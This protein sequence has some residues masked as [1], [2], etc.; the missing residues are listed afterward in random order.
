MK[1]VSVI[2]ILAVLVLSINLISAIDMDIKSSFY[3]GETMQVEIPDVFIEGLRLENIG[4]YQGD[5]VHITPAGSGLIKSGYSYFYYAVLPVSDGPYSLKIENIKYWESSSQSTEPIVRNFSIIN[6]TSSYLSFNPGYLSV[7]KDF[8]ITVLAYGKRQDVTATFAPTNFQKTLNINLGPDSY[9]TFYIP[10]TGITNV[11]KSEVKINSYTIPVI[12]TPGQAIKDPFNLSG[13]DQLKIINSLEDVMDFY[14]E[15]IV[16]TLLPGDDYLYEIEL[17]NEINASIENL[18]ISS[19]DKEIKVSPQNI[20]ELKKH[21][22]IKINVTL[23]FK[24]ENDGWINVTYQNYSIIIPVLIKIAEIQSDVQ[25]NI[26]TINDQKTC[27][28]LGGAKCDSSTNQECSGSQTYAFDGWCCTGKCN[29]PTS[30]STWLFGILLL[31]ILGVIGWFVYDKS[32]QGQ[33]AEKIKE[34]FKRRTSSYE[35]RIKPQSPPPREIRGG[36]SK[37]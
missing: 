26:E 36:L 30:S 4:I 15:E 5:N 21:D 19:S 3:P 7:T 35:N 33:G 27:T 37:S 1:K 14:P 10:I 25:S 9:K 34:L 23:N 13:E 6:T 17:T 11:T 16:A 31:I 24:Q 20:G 29:S 18:T 22:S 8:S 32:Q 28:E 2:P 12:I